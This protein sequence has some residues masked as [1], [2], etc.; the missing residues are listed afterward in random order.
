MSSATTSAAGSGLDL[1]GTI[2]LELPDR[3]T[4]VTSWH[5]H[6]PFAFWCVEALRPRV[7]VELGTH[8][9]DSYSAFCQAVHA[10]SLPT[11]CY[12]VDTWKGDPH[13]GIY[14]DEVYL[15]LGRYHDPRYSA[16]SRLVRSTF[17]EAVSNFADGSID[18][19]HID[20]LHTYEAVRQDFETWLPKLSHSAVVLFHDV[21]VRE[22]DFGAWRYWQELCSRYPHFTF[23]HGHGLGVLVVGPDAPEAAKRLASCDPKQAIHVRSFFSRQGSVVQ[24]WGERQRLEPLTAELRQRLAGAE[25]TLAARDAQVQEVSTGLAACQAK[26]EQVSRDLAQAQSEARHPLRTMFARLLYS[27]KR[28]PQPR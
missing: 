13:A 14:G 20:G 21:N 22:R 10:L 18:L 4:D 24:A 17:D 25:E 5:T 2:V 7:L 28:L 3:L 15:D 12:A 26:L 6:I 8:K 9:G 27:G 23:L 11:A 19:L 16:F 1:L